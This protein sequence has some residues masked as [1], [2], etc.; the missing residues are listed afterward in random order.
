MKKFRLKKDAVPFFKE[1][2]AKMKINK[3][4]AALEW[5]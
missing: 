5:A 2:L 1:G 3:N 4:G